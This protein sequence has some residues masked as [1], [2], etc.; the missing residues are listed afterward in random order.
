MLRHTIKELK[1]INIIFQARVDNINAD[2]N[3]YKLAID[4][5]EKAL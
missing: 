3:D 4:D 1:Y 5:L 2:E